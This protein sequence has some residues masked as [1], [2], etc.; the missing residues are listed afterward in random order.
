MEETVRELLQGMMDGFPDFHVDMGKLR[1]T[2]DA[3]FGEGLITGTHDG[4]WAGMPPTR[5]RVVFPIVAIFEFDGDR[6]L[7]EK[8]YFDMAMVLTQI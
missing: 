8:V 4:E 2:D 5:R 3:V 1:H 6:L 7:C